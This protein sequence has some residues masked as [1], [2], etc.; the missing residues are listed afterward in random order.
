MPAAWVVCSDG[1][2]YVSRCVTLPNSGRGRATINLIT[3]GSNA[4]PAA[5]TTNDTS[6]SGR[7]QRRSKMK[8]IDNGASSANDPSSVTTRAIDVSVGLEW[9]ATHCMVAVSKAGSQALM[10]MPIRVTMIASPKK[11]ASTWRM[12]RPSQERLM[13][14]V[15]G[16]R[17]KHAEGGG[18]DG[19]R[20]RDL[21]ADFA[22]ERHVH[23]F[24]RSDRQS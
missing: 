7:F 4:V 21:A 13:V 10:A 2:L 22:I 14:V 16:Q 17:G 3:D 19:E 24:G 15:L 9:I 18:N 8:A 23:R 11:I 1:K 5:I 20:P 6:S 12:Y